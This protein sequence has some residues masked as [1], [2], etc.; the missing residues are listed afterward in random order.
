M[1]REEYRDVYLKSDHW[2]AQRVAAL[3][4]AENRCQ[5]CNSDRSLDVHHRTYERLGSEVPA[6]LTVLC[7]TCHDLFHGSK[8]KPKQLR[9]PKAK[10]TTARNPLYGATGPVET[11]MRLLPV[12]LSVLRA[13]TD[14]P[15]AVR[16]VAYAIGL[17]AGKTGLQMAHLREL[18]HIERIKGKQKQWKLTPK[19][20][21][22]AT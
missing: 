19:G 18:G 4:R 12:Q 17:T 5:V 6:D 11:R 22:E 21:K 10:P 13:L 1:N 7:R 15:L 9:K 8:A 16:E 2:R 14:G 3:V 20:R